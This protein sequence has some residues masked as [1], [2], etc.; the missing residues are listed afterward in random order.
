MMIRSLSDIN[1]E[2]LSEII[3]SHTLEPDISPPDANSDVGDLIA[4]L[5]AEKAP[6]PV[7]DSGTGGFAPA[8]TLGADDFATSADAESGP[9]YIPDSISKTKGLGGLKLSKQFVSIAGIIIGIILIIV[10][11]VMLL[12][13]SSGLYGDAANDADQTRNGRIGADADADVELP[14]ED[15]VS[16]A[17]EDE[18]DSENGRGEIDN[19]DLSDA[20]AKDAPAETK[21]ASLYLYVLGDER[22]EDADMNTS[23]EILP[24]RK[25]HLAERI[26]AY[27]SE[28]TKR[29]SL[30]L[31]SDEEINS[32]AEFISL[33]VPANEMVDAVNAG[34]ED[35]TRLLEV[36]D[37]REKAYGI[38][39]LSVL[40]K[41]LAVDYEDL[42][43]YYAQNYSS[44]S[45]DA[46]IYSV[47]YRME[48][49]S[50]LHPE[51]GARRAEIERVGK[52]F[53]EISKIED[54]DAE[55]KWHAKLI[56]S[57]LF[58]ISTSKA[59]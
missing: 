26:E 38:Y 24:S 52:T 35:K 4:S 41:L 19:A 58:D 53:T 28:E 46:F 13:S 31:P 25:N 47:K 18:I 5:E 10:A 30:S 14:G 33:T 32:D 23:S 59:Y 29:K 21:V 36:I 15:V 45:L 9:A 49:L 48:Y 22:L 57:C 55:R 43:L 44:E 2:F 40:K 51:S 7:A 8:Q 39:P 16:N 6:A 17:G 56:A 54:L 12:E 11:A 50:D 42:G 34:C 27:I 3:G 37:L 1:K 20:A